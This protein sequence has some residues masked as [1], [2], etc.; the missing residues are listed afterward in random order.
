MQKYN[1]VCSSFASDPNKYL[2]IFIENKPTLLEEKVKRRKRI[3]CQNFWN[4]QKK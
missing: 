2:T 4:D 1:I 3:T